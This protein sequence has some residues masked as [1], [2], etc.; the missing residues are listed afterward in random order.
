MVDHYLTTAISTMTIPPLPNHSYIQYHHY[1]TTDLVT[2]GALRTYHHYHTT[3]FDTIH[4]YL[5][6]GIPLPH[7]HDHT[8]VTHHKATAT[9]PRHTILC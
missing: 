1:H 2:Y 7:H 8:T 9:T 4:K 5:Q 6:Y 3:A